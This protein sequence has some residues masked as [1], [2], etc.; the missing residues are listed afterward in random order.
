MGKAG[1]VACIFTPY[2]LTIISILCIILVGLGS[3][4]SSSDT[5]NDLY[6]VRFDLSNITTGSETLSKIEDI[7]KKADITS[8]KADEIENTIKKF[9]D[10]ADIAD[11]YGIGLWGNCKGNST[12]GKFDVSSCTE[13]KA[14]YYFNP[15]EILGLSDEQL[16]KELGSGFKKTMNVY[17]AVS[18][19]MFIAYVI[20]FIA[21]AAQLLVGVVAIFSRWG[22][23]VTTIIS[24]VAFLFT[25]AASLTSTIMFSIA[26]GSLGTPLKLYGIKLIMGKNMF[27]ATWL[28]VVF[29]FAATLFW[30]FSTCCCSGRSPYGHKDRDHDS[31]PAEKAP[32]NYD[33]VGAAH[34]PPFSSQPNALQHGYNTSYPTP[35]YNYTN[36]NTNTNDNNQH[37]SAYE[38]FRHV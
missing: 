6:F 33:P 21:T 32:Y 9:Q 24:L 37:S 11:F 12:K 16:E 14:Q 17:K 31:V 23:C 34:P 20:A 30:T 18:K 22:S 8:V 10:N 25:L 15:S 36:Y 7:L 2:V 1:R 35:A 3:T 5:L 29:S 26:K 28:A 38:P 19:W 13:P 4:R 27:A